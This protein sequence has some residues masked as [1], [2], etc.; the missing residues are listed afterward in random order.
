MQQEFVFV[1][2]AF[3]AILTRDTGQSRRKSG[4]FRWC[5][6]FCGSI[7]PIGG[8]THFLRLA[9]AA[10]LAVKHAQYLCDA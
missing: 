8:D 1:L 6:R 9:E 7:G 3:D 4:R 10:F 2:V 5:R